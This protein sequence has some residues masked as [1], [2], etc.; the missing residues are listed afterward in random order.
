MHVQINV[1]HYDNGKLV[2]SGKGHSMTINKVMISPDQNIVVSVGR[3]G[4]IFVW[5]LSRDVV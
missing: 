2:A 4:G 3:E 1:W 5:Q